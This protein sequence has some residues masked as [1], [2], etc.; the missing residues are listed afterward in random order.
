MPYVTIPRDLTKIKTKM[1]LGLTKRQVISFGI[2]AALALPTYFGLRETIGDTF[3]AMAMIAI[4]VPSFFF[5]MYERDGLPAHKLVIY[6]IKQKFL[7]PQVRIYR[8]DS[9]QRRYERE[10]R[11]REK[12]RTA[13]KRAK[14]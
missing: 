10:A 12:T 3:A 1:V 6:A 7:L 5:A 14:T 11:K 9:T 8:T 2:G 4:A 13:K